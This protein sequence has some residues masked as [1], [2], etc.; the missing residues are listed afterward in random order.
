MN[1]RFLARM[2]KLLGEDY[3]AYEAS[4]SKE[5][6]R[7]IRINMLRSDNHPVEGLTLEPS[8]FAS[9]G[10]YVTTDEKIGGRTEYLTG[11]IY[12]QEPSASFAVTAMG[13]EP[14]MKV[15]DLCAAPG[16]K[17]TEIA[18]QLSHTGLLVANEI[19][20]KRA[21][22]L[23]ENIERHG[24]ANVIITSGSPSELADAFPE[25]FDAVLCDAPC[26]GEGMFRRNP[27]AELEWSEAHVES[28]AI[29]QNLILQD[30]VRLVRPGGVLVYSTCT[31]SREENEAN[32]EQLLSEYPCL[33]LEEIPAAGGRSGL[34][35]DHL[36]RRIYPMDGGEGHFVAR[37]RKA[38]GASS[39]YTPSIMKS[40]PI[41]KE[42]IAFLEEHLERPYPYLFLNRDTLYGGTVPF[43][44]CSGVHL[45]RHQV[46][47]GTMRH[48][49][50]EPS[51]AMAMSAYAP[52]KPTIELT[53]EE[54]E[55]YRR[56]ETIRKTAPKGWAAVTVD[57]A[58]AG[59]VK[60][61]GQLLKNHYPKAF[62]IR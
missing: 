49:R 29:R 42:A 60:S 54:F 44:S 47:L 17:S 16:S 32:V 45:I 5:P 3:E 61:D 50:F 10:W 26:S 14:G 59:L 2:R 41:P 15:L 40:D 27:E 30:A 35:P 56:G 52:F 55:R 28:C 9:N 8:L 43:I 6:Y 18:E 38:D 51:H 31:F 46:L 58:A 57:G 11:L 1:A 22:I 33:N 7:G 19:V 53:K 4:L 62:R 25:Y 36:T 12:S 34:D 39:G 24:C 48:N 23:A 21:K 20:P 37:F 13:I